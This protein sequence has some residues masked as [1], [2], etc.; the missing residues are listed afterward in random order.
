MS[1]QFYRHR[2]IYHLT[3]DCDGFKEV[4]SAINVG[5]FV[6]FLLARCTA[7]KSMLAFSGGLRWAT[8]SD[9]LLRLRISDQ[10]ERT[11]YTVEK[12]T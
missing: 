11:F 6:G 7:V 1:A 2:C 8:C 10:S 12:K 5:T 9:N 3:R 4:W